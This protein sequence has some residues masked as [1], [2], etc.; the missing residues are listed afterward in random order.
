[1][2]DYSRAAF[3]LGKIGDEVVRLPETGMVRPMHQPKLPRPG[4]VILKNCR[5][6]C[7]RNRAVGQTAAH[8]HRCR[9]RRGNKASAPRTL[10]ANRF[11]RYRASDV[12]PNRK[13]K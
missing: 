13:M 7:R 8:R 12:A 4:E 5:R 6:S 10:I 3:A 2:N 9:C 1:H 11:S